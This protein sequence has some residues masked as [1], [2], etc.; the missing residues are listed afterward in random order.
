[1]KNEHLV[2][3]D[4][5]Y[6]GHV[7][8]F[9]KS[10]G[11]TY[12]GNA[13]DVIYGFFRSILVL[14]R[15]FETTRFVFCWDAK[16]YLREKILPS[17]KGNRKPLDLSEEQ[18]AARDVAYKQFNEIRLTALPMFGFE[19]VFLKSGYESDDLIASVVLNNRDKK[20]IVVTND[21]DLFQLLDHCSIFHYSE[22]M[23]TDKVLFEREYGISP[24][25]WGEV[26]AIAG[27]N[28]DAVPGI[29]GVGIKTAIQYLK[30]DLTKGKKFEAIEGGTEI[31]ER[32]KKLVVLPFA[33]TRRL[34]I[35]KSPSQRSLVAFNAFCRY[36]GF[37]SFQEPKY[38]NEW[39]RTFNLK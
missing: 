2:V 10:Q 24:S 32:N 3:V 27:C 28:S 16:E 18:A 38:K 15:Q 26:K 12:R 23:I 7:N 39:I 33:G 21:N 35:K 5:N 36:Y 22:K 4:C 8:I 20:S 9:A 11:L 14:A 6:L 30:G 19:N 25:K 29:V 13:T 1:M 17:Y 31:I 37:K 34:P